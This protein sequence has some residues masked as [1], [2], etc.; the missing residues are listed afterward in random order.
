MVV[1]M[2]AYNEWKSIVAKICRR[3]LDGSMTIEEFYEQWPNGQEDSEFARLVYG[4]IEDGVQHFP[5]KLISGKPDY[6]L[7]R[8][9][10]IY[11][12]LV[13]AN[14][15]LKLDL[16]EPGLLEI[17]SLLLNDNSVPI[18]DMSTK[19]ARLGAKGV[20]V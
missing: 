10:D 11:R 16:D 6:E 4:D 5:A 14:E 8:S 2:N 13:I 17:R 1:M 15:V 12:R 19:A 20:G 3:A 9:S 18:K 7:W